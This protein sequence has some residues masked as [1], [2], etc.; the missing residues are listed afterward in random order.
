[1]RFSDASG[2]AP[3]EPAPLDADYGGANC[4]FSCQ[5]LDDYVGFYF[6]ASVS[7]GFSA[8]IWDDRRS[9][10]AEEQAAARGRPLTPAER[11][12]ATSVFG[13]L[14]LDTVRIIDGSYIPF[15]KALGYVITPNGNVYWPDAC[16]DLVACGQG[17]LFL[18]EMTH[19]WQ[20]QR[21]V[22]VIGRRIGL[23]W[24]RVA[25]LWQYNPYRSGAYDPNRPLSSYNMERQGEVA[26]A[27]F[28]TSLLPVWK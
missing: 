21:G 14:G 18:H 8:W 7:Y 4:T 17:R 3:Q 5:N 6:N 20:H 24:A 26:V 15:Q 2:L 10:A 28:F 9:V 12:L 25:S 27:M 23:F 22:N 16:R 13:T 1:M 11:A 19:V